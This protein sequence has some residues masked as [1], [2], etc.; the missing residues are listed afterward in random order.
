MSSRS[1]LKEDYGK[2]GGEKAFVQ[3]I[4]SSYPRFFFIICKPE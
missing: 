4:C 1:H 3:E 2:E